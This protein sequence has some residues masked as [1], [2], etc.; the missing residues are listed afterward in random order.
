MKAKH[1]AVAV[2][3]ALCALCAEAADIQLYGS[4]DTGLNYQHVDADNGSDATSQLQM[5]SSQQTPNRWGMR[6][7]EELNAG[8]KVGFNLE[9]QFGSDDGTMTGGRLFNR[10]SNVYVASD[11]Y[12]TLFLGR[13]GQLRSGMGV[14]G[15]WATK[16]N[17]FSNSWGDYIVGA[18][19]IMPGNFGSVDN[20]ITY[21]TPVFAGLQLHAQY[22]SQMNTVN[23]LEDAVEN[24]NSSDRT[25]A[26]GATYTNGPL[27]I[28]AILDSVM[29]ATNY[30]TDTEYKDS[31][32]ASL[33]GAYDFGVVK[34]YL[35]G[36]YFSD[37]KGS[38]FLGHTG[39]MADLGVAKAD[40]TVSAAG[41]S[42]KGYS[43]FRSAPTFRWRAARSRPTSVG[44]T[45]TSITSTWTAT[46]TKPIDS[47]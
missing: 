28:V 33:G 37:M 38:D 36:M 40:G 5:K 35:S 47:R 21:R 31:L 11:R 46:A 12:G 29:Y 39:G 15:I 9:G 8:V 22:S 17:P 43:H 14:T 45:R 7:S 41:A 24:K 19:Y 18:K 32:A 30:A 42:Y 2:G 26:I 25:W 16:L 27:H 6:G 3:S 23:A 1:I 13:A 20:S 4:I 44:W 34:L 10:E